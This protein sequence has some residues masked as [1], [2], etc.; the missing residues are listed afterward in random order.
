[1]TKFAMLFAVLM[2]FTGAAW[3]ASSVYG[4][5]RLATSTQTT[6][7]VLAKGGAVRKSAITKGAEF[8]SFSRDWSYS[9]TDWINRMR[10]CHLFYVKPT[11]VSQTCSLRELD[12]RAQVTYK[13]DGSFTANFD[14]F[15][16]ESTD[17]NGQKYNAA[18]LDRTG[19]AGLL[20]T[21]LGYVPASLSTLFISATD[22]GRLVSS[23]KALKGSKKIVFYAFWNDHDDPPK[24]WQ[25]RV[26]V[27]VK[28]S[29]RRWPV[30]SACCSPDAAQS[31]QNASDSAAFL[32]A[33]E[34][35][36]NVQKTASGLLYLVLQEGRG[37][38][39]LET[40]S[41]VVNYRG[42]LPSGSAFDAGS[43]VS[44]G[45]K[46]VLDGWI[47][48]LQ[49]MAPGAKYRFFIPPELAYKTV[50]KGATIGPNAA[51]VFDVELV[52]VIKA[53]Q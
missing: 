8:A 30:D 44:F 38:P 7:T 12:Q 6:V 4:V 10:L 31:E 49:L 45:V 43:L 22:G 50:G 41:V 26:D 24:A 3:P 21:A 20:E 15:L 16:L 2:A 37:D 17:Q 33:V 35:Q 47:E 18:F 14:R 46:N 13:A 11:D 42:V 19:Y 53:A 25:A 32:A 52:K 28:Y 40:D 5:W 48:G 34:D 9:G 23:G 1:M 51:L 39:P 27:A 36:P 29:G